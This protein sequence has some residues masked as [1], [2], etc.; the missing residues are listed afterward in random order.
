ME[1]RVGAIGFESW[2]D[3]DFEKCRLATTSID[4]GKWW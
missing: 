1:K 4:A 2:T 3:R